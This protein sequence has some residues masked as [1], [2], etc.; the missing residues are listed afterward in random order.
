MKNKVCFILPYFGNFPANFKLWLSSC[1]NNCDFYWKI[2]TDDRRKYDYPE[3]VY[4]TYCTLSDLEKRFQMKL[5]E[6]CLLT[7]PY[8]LCDY[9]PLY[10]VL[11]EDE[12]KQYSHWGYCDVDLIFGNLSHFITDNLLDE[13]DKLS[14]LGHLSVLK[15]NK[16]VNELFR[17]CDYLE[18]LNNPKTRTFD[19]IRFEPNI[20]SLMA[21]EKMRILKTFPYSD[22]GWLH[23][24]FRTSEY[25]SGNRCVLKEDCPMLF[26]YKDKCA[27]QFSF[28]NEKIYQEEI[29]YF[30]FQKRNVEVEDDILDNFLFVP[31]RFIRYINPTKQLLIEFSK[32]NMKY[33]MMSKI[34]QIKRAIKNRLKY[35]K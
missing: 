1:K 13:Y 24:K 15:N 19:E 11:F 30:H 16:R 9:K 4:V 23:Y 8:K 34:K 10:G 27:Y 31:N 21:K 25:I 2:Y 6:K 20:N 5:K 7:S 26:A 18:I 17:K 29:A 3:N 12:L 32:D 35:T 22:I 33:Y 14:V 28:R